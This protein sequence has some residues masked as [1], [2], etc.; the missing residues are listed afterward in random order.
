MNAHDP[1]CLGPRDANV[2]PVRGA[3]AVPDR[4]DLVRRVPALNMVRR[5]DW[6]WSVT[7]HEAQVTNDSGDVPAVICWDLPFPTVEPISFGE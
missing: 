7:S 5:A 3:G 6:I 2:E 4:D 1:F